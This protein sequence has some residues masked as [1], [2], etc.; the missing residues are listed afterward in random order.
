MQKGGNQKQGAEKRGASKDLH[1][2]KKLRAISRTLA[3]LSLS[4]TAALHPGNK[5]CPNLTYLGTCC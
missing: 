3:H 5:T 2:E 1:A 4:I